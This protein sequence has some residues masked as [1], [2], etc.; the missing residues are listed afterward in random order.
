MFHRDK[1]ILSNLTRW[2]VTYPELSLSGDTGRLYSASIGASAVNLT[3]VGP[4]SPTLSIR[5]DEIEVN[6][7]IGSVQA[8]ER[9]RLVLHMV[10]AKY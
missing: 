10:A 3:S 1:S 7:E 2:R 8:R 4:T 6:E 9:G 5:F